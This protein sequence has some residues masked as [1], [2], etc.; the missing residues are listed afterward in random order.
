MATIVSSFRL[1]LGP[2]QEDQLK[3]KALEAAGHPVYIGAWRICRS[4]AEFF[5]GKWQPPLPL[6]LEINPF[7]QRCAGVKGQD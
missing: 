5:F 7:D 1:V 6:R 3:L 4:W 2:F